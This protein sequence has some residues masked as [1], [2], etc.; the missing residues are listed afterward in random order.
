MHLTRLVDDLLDMGRITSGKMR[1]DVQRVELA[2]VVAAAI[3]TAGPA[4]DAKGIRL[5]KILD[6]GVVVSGDPGR[7][8]QV[9]WNLLSNAVK[10]TPKGGSIR[11]VMGRVNSHIEVSVTDS[12]QGMKAEFIAHAFE[13]FRQSDTKG[14]QKTGGL[15]LGLS[16]VKSLVEMHGGSVRAASEGEGKGSTFVVHLPVAVVDAR[17]EGG[18]RVHPRPAITDGAVDVG[19]I[20]LAGVKVV[21]VDDEPDAREMIRRALVASGAEV[22]AA[23]S[24]AE[25]LDA[26]ERFRPDVMV[27]DIGLPEQDGYELIRRVRMLGGAGGVKAVALTAFARLEDRT[28]AMLAGYQMHLAKPVEPSEL[29]VTV[30]SLAGRVAVG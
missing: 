11:V 7:L 3:E 20:S 30:A 26:V 5:Q 24:A 27:S 15:G 9:F 22:V 1:L 6:P 10:F 21:V 2:G 25:A 8:Q 12:G 28:R 16:I 18:D 14:T 19:A 17:Q 29:V 23:G 4:A 13:R